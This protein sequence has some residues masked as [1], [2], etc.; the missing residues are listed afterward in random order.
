LFVVKSD[1]KNSLWHGSPLSIDEIQ[2]VCGIEDVR[3]VDEWESR[4]DGEF[5]HRQVGVKKAE[6]KE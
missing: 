4:M 2:S 5:D 3:Y 6:K 1:E